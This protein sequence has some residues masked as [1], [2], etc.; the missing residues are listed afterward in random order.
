[1]SAVVTDETVIN[2]TIKRLS[3]VCKRVVKQGGEG[4]KERVKVLS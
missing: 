1:M 3:P 4:V 2:N